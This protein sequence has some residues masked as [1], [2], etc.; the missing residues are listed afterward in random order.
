MNN[1]LNNERMF[2]GIFFPTNIGLEVQTRSESTGLIQ[3][4]NLH[5]AI[6]AAIRDKTIWKIS[7]E[8]VVGHKRIIVAV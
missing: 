8:S 6:Q 4:L 7:Y 2:R 1:P 3:H 5:H